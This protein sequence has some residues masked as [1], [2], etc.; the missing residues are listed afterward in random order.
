MAI[1]VTRPNTKSTNFRRV[2]VCP[3]SGGGHQGVAPNDPTDTIFELIRQGGN[4]TGPGFGNTASVQGTVPMKSC[5]V[6]GLTY[7]PTSNSKPAILAGAVGFVDFDG[8]TIAQFPLHMGDVV[9]IGT[10][11]NWAPFAKLSEA[12]VLNDALNASGL[13]CLGVRTIGDG[14]T[15]ACRIQAIVMNP[16]GGS[17]TVPTWL[18][19][20]YLI[21]ID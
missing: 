11:A 15:N 3:H 9:M 21:R 18:P 14:T 6:L 19:N 8:G 13:I 16:T 7:V 12:L 4:Y 1:P 5:T 10:T 2:N 20:L 17:I